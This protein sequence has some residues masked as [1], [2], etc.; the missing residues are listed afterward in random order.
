MKNIIKKYNYLLFLFFFIIWIILIKLNLFETIDNGIYYFS[1]NFFSDGMTLFMKLITFLASPVFLVGILVLFLLFGKKKGL[2]IVCSLFINQLI[3]EVVKYLL[4]RPRPSFSHYVV[5]NGY[6][7][8]SG[9][10]MGAC[11]FYGTLLIFLWNSKINNK[12]KII[13]TIFLVILIS[14]IGFSRIYLGVHYFSDIIAGLLLA[15]VIVSLE[16]KCYKKLD[17]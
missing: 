13:I 5:E 6:S 7:C 3:N 10:M 15:L 12:L 8:P 14:L 16:V 11:V 2:F 9:H 1:Q 4:K 17:L